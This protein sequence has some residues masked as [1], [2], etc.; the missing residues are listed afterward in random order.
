M[1]RVMVVTDIR[2]YRD[3]L[4]RYLGDQP[5]VE[6]VGSAAS[7]REG[8]RQVEE[9]RPDIVLMD[10]TLLNCHAAVRTIARVAPAT[11]VVVLAMPEEEQDLVA[12]AEAGV[13]GFVPREAS[14]AELVAA[15]QRAARDEVLVPPGAA[16]ALLRRVALLAASSRGAGGGVELT[17]REAEIASLL[18]E[19]KSNKEIA[20]G[21]GIEVATV[22]NHVHHILEKLKVHRRAEVPRTV[23]ARARRGLVP[24]GTEGRVG[25]L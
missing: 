24:V 11:R 16:S 6:V 20:V 12:C 17:R 7:T 13:A 23:R 4:V 2:L 3:G 8:I 18:D 22:K 19:G 25:R 14:L 9:L 21:L 1:I 15:V 10:L 5:Q